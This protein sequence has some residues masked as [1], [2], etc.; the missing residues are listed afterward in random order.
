M[1]YKADR[2][3]DG[4]DEI[5]S[6]PITG[7]TPVRLNVDPEP[8][9]QV[10][11]Y[12]I[13]PASQ[14]VVYIVPRQSGQGFAT[15]AELFRVP[16]TGGTSV[17]LNAPLVAGGGVWSF[18]IS[19]D[20]ARVVYRADQEADN[21]FELYSV[22][23][24][25]SAPPVK[26]NKP[27]AA[28]GDVSGVFRITPDSSRVIY[29]ADQD[30]ND[31]DELYSVPLAGPAAGGIKL[32]PP[33]VSGGDVGYPPASAYFSLSPD[34][35]RVVYYADQETDGRIELFSAAVSTAASSVKLNVELTSGGMI[36]NSDHISPDGSHVLYATNTP[37]PRGVY[38]VPI[39]G[40]ASASVLLIPDG[41]G[42]SFS[43]D[44]NT[45][46]GY[47]PDGASTY[48]TLAVPATGPAG[49]AIV[50]AT[51]VRAY[52]FTGGPYVVYSIAAGGGPAVDVYSVPIT[53]PATAA[54]QLNQATVAGDLGYRISPDGTRLVYENSDLGG[55]PR[56]LFSVPITGPYTDSVK[57]S[58]PLVSG[59]NVEYANGFNFSPDGRRVVYRADAETDG[60]IELYVT[61]EGNLVNNRVYLPLIVR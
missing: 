16:I 11:L 31:V 60:K 33:L 30:T 56:E 26:L 46:V 12:A 6:V 27:L 1:V 29:I 51:S 57:I 43:A 50:L 59:G 53:G 4:S 25:G 23:L 47:R 32:N 15:P 44:G 49:S 35:T 24:D 21:V 37:S 38:R 45:V 8:P 17:K 7:G 22:P 28:E 39:T 48:T 5:Y 3:S 20:S 19:P 58:G 18:T 54:V 40:P 10:G 55:N 13:S 14:W 9:F 42:G 52:Q 41:W 61:D 2:L 36:V 34:G